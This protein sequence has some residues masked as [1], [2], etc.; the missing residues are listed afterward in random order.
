MPSA[1]EPPVAGTTSLNAALTFSSIKKL[2]ITRIRERRPN[3][4]RSNGEN[5]ESVSASFR[6]TEKRNE[7]RD[8]G[9]SSVMKYIIE[10][11]KYRSGN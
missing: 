9:C 3:S 4:I 2:E 11:K 1:Y 10:T 8:V 5:C 7:P 6:S